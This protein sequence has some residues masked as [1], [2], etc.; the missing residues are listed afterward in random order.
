MYDLAKEFTATANII[1][2]KKVIFLFIIIKDI[3]WILIDF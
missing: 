1:A 3:K 2:A